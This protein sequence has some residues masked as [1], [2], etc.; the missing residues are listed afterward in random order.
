MVESFD[1]EFRTLFAASLPIPETWRGDSLPPDDT[2]EIKDFAEFS[3][4]NHR[5]LEPERITPPS[6]LADN[7]LDW[8]AMGVI[9]RDSCFPDSPVNHHEE[10]MAIERPLANNILFDAKTPVMDKVSYNRN[11]FQDQGRYM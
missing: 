7:P 4:S 9:Q 1:K 6:P 5:T 3:F 2:H 11:R 8:E 10:I